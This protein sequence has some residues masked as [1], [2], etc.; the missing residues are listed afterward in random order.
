MT[1]T[2]LF[3]LY[4]LV[5]KPVTL[6]LASKEDADKLLAQLRV[7]KSRNSQS[8][9][10]LGMSAVDNLAGKTIRMTPAQDAEQPAAGYR[11]SISVENY[12]RTSSFEILSI[13]IPQL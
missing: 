2:D 13:E 8:M 4:I 6:T 9:K 7:A 10:E 5:E 11:V 3:R 12:V 1:P